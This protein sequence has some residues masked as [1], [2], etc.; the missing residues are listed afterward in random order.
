M[1]LS[2]Y[3]GHAQVVSILLD[4]GSDINAVDQYGWSALMLAAYAG[5]FDVCKL[6][7][8][9]GAK[10]DITTANGK[11]AVEL[12]KDN[13]QHGIED[14]LSQ[15]SP[16]YVYHPVSLPSDESDPIQARLPQLS[17]RPAIASSDLPAITSSDL[18]IIASPDKT[19]RRSL[20]K[21]IEG[22]IHHRN[23]SNSDSPLL[24][25]AM[26]TPS[27]SSPPPLPEKPRRLSR[28]TPNSTLASRNR[29][30]SN[31]PYSPAMSSTRRL[32]RKSEDTELGVNGISN[33]VLLRRRTTKR[34]ARLPGGGIDVQHG[35]KS[36]PIEKGSTVDPWKMFS[37][38][39]TCWVC[40]PVLSCCGLREARMQQAWREKVALCI[41]IAL[42]SAVLGFM[43]FGLST[44]ACRQVEPIYPDDVVRL[45][46]PN[47]PNEKVMIVRGR[48]YNVGV[49]F[50][51]GAH[52]PLLGG[53]L[54]SDLQPI[55][56]PL[57]G[58]DAT[59][60]FPPN[61]ALSGCSWSQPGFGPL[62]NQ[63]GDI[64]YHC[65]TSF[66]AVK[67]LEALATSMWVGYDWDNITSPLSDQ[68]LFVYRDTVYDVTSYIDPSNTNLFLGDDQQD[69]ANIQ[70][71]IKSLVGRDASKEIV[72]NTNLTTIASCFDDYF[73][74]GQ[75]TGTTIGCF[76]SDLVMI[77]MLTILIGITI[78][79][80]IAAVAFSWIISWQLGMLSKK[81]KADELISNIFML[82]T[83]YSEGEAS[84]RRTLDALAR[85][86]YPDKHKVLF[87]IAD[88]NVTG[89]GNSKSTPDICRDLMDRKNPYEEDPDPCSYIAVG[90]GLK[91]HNMAQVY[92][93][94]YS[95]ADNLTKGVVIGTPRRVP[96][97]LIV[98]CGTDAERDEVIN[99]KRGI[100]AGNR[101]KR[102]S[103]LILMQ[104][105]SKVHF[106]ERMTELDFQ[107]FERL[108]DLTNFTP[109][110]YEMVLMVDADTVVKHDSVSRM[111][112]AMERD[113]KVMGLC[114][115]TKISNKTQS[116]VTM[117]QV[118]E[119]YISHHLAKAFESIFG[120]VTCLPG[121]FC[122]YR[123]M[124]P[125][126]EG[127]QVPILANPDIVEL[128][129]SNVV[130]TLHQKN[131]LLLGE[132]RYLTTL[133]LRTFPKRKMI[134]VPKAT[135]RTEVP[136]NFKVLFSQRRRW[137]NSTV[138]NLMEL[139]LVPELC[140]IFCCSMQFVLF[141]EIFGTVVLPAAFVFLIYLVVRMASG[142]SNVFLPLIFL[143]LVFGLQAVL[144][145]FTSRKPMYIVWM[146]IYLL[147]MPV[148]NFALPLYA[149]W[150]FDDFSWGATRRVDA[151]MMVR[152]KKTIR[153]KNGRKKAILEEVFNVESVPVKKWNE[154]MV[155][156]QRQGKTLWS[157]Q[158]ETSEE[159]EE[160]VTSHNDESY[161]EKSLHAQEDEVENED[162]DTEDSYSGVEGDQTIHHH[163][164]DE[165]EDEKNGDEDESH[166]FL[167]D[168]GPHPTPPK[169]NAFASSPGYSP[170]LLY[171]G[172]YPGSPPRQY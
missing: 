4:R 120:G 119:Y 145:L 28:Q 24:S 47:Q 20:S 50:S 16:S 134:Y 99:G 75:L 74:V 14:F 121:C 12:A 77:A 98:K 157:H 137:I 154:W 111:V 109:D 64:R 82:V 139:I 127:Y 78:I 56:S 156:A 2:A 142:A 32:R 58:R 61:T 65:H 172:A 85:T 90:E 79:K 11:D 18:P 21:R 164:E 141:L 138:H 66:Q 34:N 155:Q 17:E 123:V 3:E 153:D 152:R 116:W 31:D 135:C 110:S 113:P 161:E 140:G 171:P 146:L 72:S 37:W 87:V 51:S 125:K 151:S 33:A 133:M 7:V 104:W 53:I 1:I 128:Y 49:Y 92:T 115:E 22:M 126:S 143:V 48:L 103:Q 63:N 73:A 136:D 105:L 106:N 163:Y 57:Y 45:F 144:V 84:M 43:T 71:W 86:D 26:R 27:L 13:G 93:G 165:T 70:S 29:T 67:Q 166:G 158:E 148:W 107:M 159:T 60:F 42:A 150:H 30:Q 25:P 40:A 132:D 167:Q 147:A 15:E 162:S 89:S 130:E 81:S 9:A 41:L 112:S 118:F 62:C 168:V 39:V 44:L 97:V 160:K 59:A 36:A 94:Y 8:Q 124:A 46:G 54:D 80:F 131:L 5:R 10:T 83:C 76:A 19:P 69:Q 102:D 68:K 35:G 117:I 55:I 149:F 101:G 88:G 38:G 96:M 169:S 114:G 100:K 170:S 6:L 122:M 52:R 23:I 129:S 91:R 108:R 95:V